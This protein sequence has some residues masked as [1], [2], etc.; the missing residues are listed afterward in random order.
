MRVMLSIENHIR[1]QNDKNDDMI[2][3]LQACN[4]RKRGIIKGNGMSDCLIRLIIM[5]TLGS[6]IIDV[7]KFFE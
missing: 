3:A 6:G 7:I 1:A 5:H 4:C 2:H